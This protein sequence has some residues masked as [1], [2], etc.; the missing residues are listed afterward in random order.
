LEHECRRAKGD[1]RV[2][3]SGCLGHCQLAPA[4]IEDG[5][6]MGWV[7]AR[8]LRNELHRLGLKD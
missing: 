6:M 2:G 1:V 7:S 5:R 8:R 4:V 3:A